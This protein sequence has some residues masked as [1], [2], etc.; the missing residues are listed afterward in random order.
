MGLTGDLVG[1]NGDLVGFYGD[2]IVIYTGVNADETNDLEIQCGY[3]CLGPWSIHGR[4]F[5]V[6]NPS[7]GHMNPY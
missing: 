2:F 6:I 7:H 1:L 4:W 3:M 5:M